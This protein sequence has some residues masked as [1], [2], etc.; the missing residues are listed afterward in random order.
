MYWLALMLYSSMVTLAMLLLGLKH[1][2]SM[3]MI[4]VLQTM[5]IAMTSGI[6]LNN[7]FFSYIIVIIM[8]SG[9][10]VLFIYMASV[11][12]NEKFKT[13]LTMMITFMIMFT[14]SMWLISYFTGQEEFP[15][16][17]NM[18]YSVITLMKLFNTLSAYLTLT[19]IFYLLM[20]MIITS[21]IAG[22]SEG[23]LRMKTYE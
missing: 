14:T 8:L 16:N 21:Y 1:P 9:A 11:A 4:L 6:M 18:N 17:S 2:L 12:S 3:G 5:I 13:S 20:T 10:L 7:F 22:N 23:P 15:G 19:M